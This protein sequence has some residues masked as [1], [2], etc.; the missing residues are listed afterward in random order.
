MTSGLP[1]ITRDALADRAQATPGLD[2]LLLHGSRARGGASAGSDWDFG[3]LGDERLDA[4]VLLAGLVDTLHDD[5]IDLAN[6]A[7]AG[8]L[9]RYHAAR[10]GEVLFESRPG[11]SGQFRLAAIGFWCDAQPLLQPGYQ[12]VL[13][14]L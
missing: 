4:A 6:L 1:P 10:D 9:L 12:A 2:L 7:T 11:L 14:R 8:A 5:R 3:Y 13:D